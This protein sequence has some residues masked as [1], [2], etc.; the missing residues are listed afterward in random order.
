MGAAPVGVPTGSPGQQADS[1]AKIREAL[2][3]LTA[4]LPKLEAG[5]EPYKAVYDSIGKLSKVAPPSAEVPGVQQ[6]ALRGLQ[7]QAMQSSQMQALMRS[8]GGGGE[9]G[10]AAPA[11]A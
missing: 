4:E 9:M 7:Q 2:K 1:L 11:A 6:S 10:A 3:I 5:S 8:M